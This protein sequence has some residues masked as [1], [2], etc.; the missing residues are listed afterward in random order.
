MKSDT[1]TSYS[2]RIL[3]L[4]DKQNDLD[5][6]IKK[7]KKKEKNFKGVWGSL[8]GYHR[9]FCKRWKSHSESVKTDTNILYLQKTD[10]NT[11]RVHV[12]SASIHA[13]GLPLESCC[14]AGLMSR[15]IEEA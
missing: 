9:D 8:R 1:G 3:V 5:L 13:R 2:T 11:V 15:E 10:M 12:Q 4:D 6:F 7:K 14:T